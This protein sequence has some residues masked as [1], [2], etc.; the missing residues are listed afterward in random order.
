[1]KYLLWI[2]TAALLAFALYLTFWAPGA[3]AQEVQWKTLEMKQ[4][5]ENGYK[6]STVA[7]LGVLRLMFLPPNSEIK[8]TRLENINHLETIFKGYKLFVDVK[9]QDGVDVGEWCV[10]GGGFQVIR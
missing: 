8:E 6:C 5:T 1:M 4:E 2:T 3:N 9:R 10:V 7:D